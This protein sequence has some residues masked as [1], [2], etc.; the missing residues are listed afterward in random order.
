M[1][2][3]PLSIPKKKKPASSGGLFQSAEEDAGQLMR[4]TPNPLRR[5]GEIFLDL[6]ITGRM[7]IELADLSAISLFR[8]FE[9]KYEGG[10]L[11]IPFELKELPPDTYICVVEVEGHRYHRMVMVG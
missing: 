11:T 6:P 7:T 4:V 10:P 5:E 9:G 8:M 1:R 2:K 3:R